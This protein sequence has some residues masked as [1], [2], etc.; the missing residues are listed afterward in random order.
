MYNNGQIQTGDLAT[1][2]LLVLKKGKDDYFTRLKNLI[3]FLN[4]SGVGL[5]QQQ[6]LARTLYRL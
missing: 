5:T 1:T 6:V 3:D 4:A 2:D